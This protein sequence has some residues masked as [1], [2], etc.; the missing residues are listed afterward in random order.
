MKPTPLHDFAAGY[1][2]RDAAAVRKRIEAL[3]HV[4]EGL[5]KIPGI[6][7]KIG[8]DVILDLVPVG[9]DVIGA[10]MGAYMVWEARNLGMSKTQMARMFGNV[11][12]DFLLGAIPWI[13]AIP[14]AMFRSN[15]RNLKII[16]RHLD[17]HYPATAVV[18]NGR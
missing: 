10:A 4:L 8:L 9:G 16:K 18:E 7:Y 12:I 6:N 2:G 1:A 11:G 17:K 15:T 13:G 14:D 5:F 3:E